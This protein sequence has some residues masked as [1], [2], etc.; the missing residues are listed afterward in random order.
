MSGS[1]F[2]LFVHRFVPAEEG[3]ERPALVLLHGTG[4]N[5]DDLIPLGRMLL[6]GAALLSPRGRVL[7]NGMP[8]FFRRIAEGVFDVEDLHARGAELAEFLI[9]ARASYGLDRGLIAVG[10]SNGANIAAGMMLEGRDLFRA[11]VLIRP[12]VP[13]EPE[14]PIAL[15]ATPVWIGAGR[16]D[17]IARPEL[18]ERLVDLLRAAGA[19]VTLHWESTGHQIGIREVRVAGEWLAS[20][21]M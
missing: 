3:V 7:E 19:V 17:P 14:H 2:E 21:E 4:G 15:P 6:P 11:A 16:L 9:A 18:S 13:F 8:R 5:E 10:F 20:L 1:A 12:M